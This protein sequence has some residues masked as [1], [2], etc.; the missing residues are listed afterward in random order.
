LILASL[1]EMPTKEVEVIRLLDILID[2]KK[3]QRDMLEKLT[4]LESISL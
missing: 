4:L 1:K 3:L 2:A